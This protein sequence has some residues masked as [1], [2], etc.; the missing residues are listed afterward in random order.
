MS[1]NAAKVGNATS[2]AASPHPRS[3]H[4]DLP[5]TQ[6]HLTRDRTGARRLAIR[7]MLVAGTAG[8]RAII[9]Q[10]LLQ[11]LEPGRNGQFHQLRPRVDEEIHERQVALALGLQ[12]GAADRLC[13][14][15]VSW[16]LSFCE[17]HASGLV[18]SRITRPVRSRRLQF[19]TAIGTSPFQLPPRQQ[20]GLASDRWGE[21]EL[22]PRGIMGRPGPIGGPFEQTARACR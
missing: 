3:T 14:T 17:A 20:P 10:Y 21:S 2:R 4:L 11:H 6:H 16:R 8:G 5:A 9:F 7:L 13:E 22:G 1:A 18:T 15:F 12:L 19:S